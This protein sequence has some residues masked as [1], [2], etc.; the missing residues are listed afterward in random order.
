[1]RL[2]GPVLEKCEDPSAWVAALKRRGYTACICPVSDASDEAAVE[3]YRSAAEQADIVIAEV[4]A[5]SNPIS[6][7]E[8][9]RQKALQLCKD[10][11]ALADVMGAR[12]CVNI[13]GSLGES[14]AGAHPDNMTR[15]AFDLIVESVRS[16]IDA[17]QPTRTYYTLEMMPWIPPHSADSYA[18]L[19]AAID[20]EHFAVHL[21]PVNIISSPERHFDNGAIIRE[22]FE[23]LGPHIKSCHAKDSKLSDTLTVYL[24][25]VQPGLGALDYATYLRELDKLDPDTPLI[26]E[27]LA[28]EEQYAAGAAYIRSV[29]E[30]VGVSIR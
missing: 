4:G 18:E 21:D 8:E 3:A 13:P 28:T 10:K 25:E 1:M 26:I 2:G 12:C 24:D 19:V 22:C 20:R 6:R 23:K 14:W 11:L 9:E 17:V 29:A 15:E 5:W 30:E 7:D 16:I 27:H